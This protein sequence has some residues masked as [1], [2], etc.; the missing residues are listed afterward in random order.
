MVTDTSGEPASAGPDRSAITRRQF[1][2]GS[3]AV[4]LAAVMAGKSGAIEDLLASL[5]DDGHET[6]PSGAA[7]HTTGPGGGA[8]KFSVVRPSDLVLLDFSFYGFEREVL[9]GITTLVPTS[10]S[11]VIVVQFPPQAIGEAVYTYHGGTWDVDPPPV[12]SALSGPSWLCFTVGSAD[13][14]PFPTMT[15]ADLLDWSNWTMLMPDQAGISDA[16]DSRLIRAGNEPRTTAPDS[17][18]TAIE[19]PYAL[20]L[21]PTIYT[22]HTRAGSFSTTFVPRATP[23]VSSDVFLS[24]SGRPEAA[25]EVVDIFSAVLRQTADG[26]AITPEMVAFDT[27]DTTAAGATPENELK[28]AA[29]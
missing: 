24:T 6:V 2:G 21:A 3:A 29:S 8:V 7:G 19:Y 5:A 4:A 20:Y 11:N 18:L 28:Y 27:T 25:V 17:K 12:L 23:L 9:G 16:K 13:N 26:A 22:G 15:S 10:T 14:V 1:L